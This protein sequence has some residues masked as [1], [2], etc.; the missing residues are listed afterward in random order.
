[1]ESTVQ[2]T[3]KTIP[4]ALAAVFLFAL[5][6][7]GAVARQTQTPNIVRLAFSHTAVDTGLSKWLM[8]DFHTLHPDIE[9]V[10]FSFGALEALDMGRHGQADLVISHHQP[11]EE[12]FVREAWGTQRTVLMYNEFAF[13]GPPGDKLKLRG[14]TDIRVALRKMA[15]AEVAFFSPNRRS[16]TA[17]KLDELWA[18]AG[19][20]PDWMG[21]ERLEGSANS[22]LAAAAKFGHYAFAD[23]ATYLSM[24]REIRGRLQPLIRDLSALRNYYAI[25]PVNARQVPGVR[26]ELAETVRDYLLS[27]RGQKRIESFSL[28]ES[29]INP[30]IPAAHTDEALRSRRIEENLRVK[31]NL[32]D[33]VFVLVVVVAGLALA[34]LWL[35][36]RALS[37]SDKHRQSEE[38]FA[39]AVEGAN[40]GIWD[41]DIAGNRLYTSPRFREIM[42]IEALDEWLPDPIETWTRSIHQQDRD[43]VRQAI[44]EAVSY[45]GTGRFSIEA[46]V[47][48]VDKPTLVLIRGNTYGNVSGRPVRIA[49]AVTDI[50]AERERDDYHHQSLHDALT[51][52]P[53]RILLRD[54]LD[55]MILTL[56]R[57]RER[58]TV[59]SLDLDGFKEIND[60]NGHHI[61]DQL[62]I[63]VAAR[64]KRTIRATDTVSRFGG[65]EFVILL[66]K[67]NAAIASEIAKNIASAI[68]A[69]IAIDGKIL[70][71]HVSIGLSV[72]PDHST[73][74][75]QLLRKA[76]AAMYST[77]RGPRRVAV[78][79]ET[80]V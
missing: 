24:K 29:N 56:D 39:R 3:D 41:W 34:A 58:G 66:P 33:I 17:L 47:G 36:R 50:T 35:W 22:A 9:V 44:T 77:K 1:M 12:L 75:D 60:S 18:I 65:D 48:D 73:D 14:E 67:A 25:L 40:D 23:M 43:K 72:Y 15:G 19:V 59:M 32:L 30:F 28:D 10:V 49:G 45:T 52:L 42:H 61:G 53:N 5:T 6:S 69:P 21:Y 68:D 16:G 27:D 57:E 51:G 79:S 46:R 71:V 74:M 64:L 13:F 31:S 11:S 55:Q 8:D 78:Y 4:L 76:D 54:R 70:H 80:S 20:A 26:Q 62:L 2:R 37:I 38:R 7:G 63:E